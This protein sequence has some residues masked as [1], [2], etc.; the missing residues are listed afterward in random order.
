M[1]RTS[2]CFH[3]NSSFVLIWPAY[4]AEVG[5]IG[6]ISEVISEENILVHWNYVFVILLNT[7]TGFKVSSEPYILVCSRDTADFKRS[8]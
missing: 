4:I 1:V 7:L 8:P 6:L 5:I 3:L 2:F